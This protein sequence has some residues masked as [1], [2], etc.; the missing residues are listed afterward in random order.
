MQGKCPEIYNDV[1]IE[2]GRKEETASYLHHP[3]TQSLY[4][5]DSQQ[6]PHLPSGLW[7]Y[8]LYSSN[9]FYDLLFAI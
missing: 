8:S 6:S 2:V 5:E 7:I 1:K 9:I 4:V 3:D